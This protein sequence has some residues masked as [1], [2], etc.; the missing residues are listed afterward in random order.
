M[1]VAYTPQHVDAQLQKIGHSK[2]LF[3]DVDD[4]LI[5]P[6]AS[7]FRAPAGKSLIDQLKQALCQVNLPAI[8]SAWRLQRKVRLVHPQWPAYLQRWRQA[9]PVHGLTKMDTGRYGHIESMEVWRGQELT[10]LGLQFS[11]EAPSPTILPNSALHQGVYLTG[12]GTKAQILEAYCAACSPK[13][14]VVVDDRIEQLQALKIWCQQHHQSACLILFKGARILSGSFDPQI[15]FFQK[16]CL[17][18]HQR[19]LED[20]Q[21]KKLVKQYTQREPCSR[22]PSLNLWLGQ[23]LEEDASFLKEPA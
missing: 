21:A 1:M 17:L 9:F 12:P 8:I 14:I 6:C 15:A 22:G 20:A 16:Y 13:H 4:T 19:W 2:V 3:L 5:T 18:F 11:Q 10:R 23:C 7:S